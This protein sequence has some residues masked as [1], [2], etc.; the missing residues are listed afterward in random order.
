MDEFVTDNL[1]TKLG[2]DSRSVTSGPLSGELHSSRFTN[3]RK[4]TNSGVVRG[5]DKTVKSK[6]VRNIHKDGMTIA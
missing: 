6:T 4:K 3:Q 1:C 5:T 2:T